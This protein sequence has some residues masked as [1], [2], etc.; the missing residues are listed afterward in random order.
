M[1][2]KLREL[3]DGKK[4]Q[5]LHL[6]L[7]SENS[8]DIAQAFSE[9]AD[10]DMIVVFRLLGKDKAVDTFAYLEPEMQERLIHAMTDNELKV[11]V[12]NLFMDDTVD[13]IEE[14]PATVVKRIIKQAAP[15]QRKIINELLNY[16]EDSAGSVMTTEFVDLK[17]KMTVEIAINK[18]RKTGVN[19]ETIYTCY[20]LDESRRLNGIVTVK[21]LLLGS[22]ETIIEDI[23]ETNLI[24][25]NTLEDQESIVKKI[26]KY[27]L[28][29]IPVV[30][31]EQRM[32]GIITIDD[33]IDVLQDENTEDFE[34]MA[35]MAPTVDT[36]FRTSV[37][38]HARNRIVWLLVLMFSSTVTGILTMKYEAAFAAVPLL[39]AFIPMLTDTGGNCGSQSS[40]LVIRGMAIDEIRIKDFF[41]VLLKEISVG[42]IVGVILAIA[43]GARIFIQYNNLR[44]ALVVSLTIIVVVLMS[45]MLGCILPMFA[46]KI[47][48][49]PAMMAAPLITTIVDICAVLVYFSIAVKILQLG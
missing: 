35:A 38:Q 8:A 46:A 39:V 30:D 11:V 43:N 15:A 36:Y 4:F 29:A 34:I 24:T 25:A 16:P 40:T 32:V 3:I 21:D 48:L 37:F 33:A 47:K 20:V 49:D 13:L 2:E 1:Q 26:N 10:E 9:I 31:K 18:I 27:D 41:R 45:K 28:L 6:M 44:M 22:N 17:G 42:F 14:M 12:S 23:M 7:E 5:E 19:K